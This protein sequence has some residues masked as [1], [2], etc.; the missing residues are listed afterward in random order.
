MTTNELTIHTDP[1]V[2]YDSFKNEP[3]LGLDLETTGINFITDDIAVIGI[4][5][6]TKNEVGIIHTINQGLPPVIKDLLENNSLKITQNGTAFDLPFLM[7]MDIYVHQHYDILIAEQVINTTNRKDVRNNLNAIMERRLG[8][9]FKQS[10]NHSSWS[11]DQLSPEQI[12]YITSDIVHLPRIYRIQQQLA[13][14][15]SLLESLESEQKLTT[16]TAQI[17]YNGLAFSTEKLHQLREESED[18]ELI[19]TYDLQR[20]FGWNF[21]PRSSQQ[22]IDV[23]NSEFNLNILDTRAGTLKPL[24]EH[25]DHIRKIVEVREASK[26]AGIYNSSFED[27]YITHDRLYA[28]YWQLGTDTTRFTSS[29]PN[30]Q[31]IPKDFR[32]VIGNESGHKVI[33]ADFS[34]IEIRV[35]AD[36]SKDPA[37]I[38][39]LESEDIHAQMASAIF[40]TP[41]PTSEQRFYGKFGTFTWLFAGGPNGI[42]EMAKAAGS[43]IEEEAAQKMINNLR[44]R[45]N[46][47]SQWHASERRRVN[48]K[49]PVIVYLPWGHRRVVVPPQQT[50][51]RLI[52]TK[53]QGTAAVGFKEALIEANRQGLT[54]YIGGLVHDEI[55]A[56]SVPEN[57]AEDY[58]ATLREAMITGM[59][60]VCVDVPVEVESK[61]ADSWTKE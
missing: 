28:K 3:F 19:Y 25:N 16:I 30:L 41:T 21:N 31:Q 24:A 36:I 49:Y 53:V 59:E 22:V 61:I 4:A 2:I 47:V 17:I 42:M 38:S 14:K 15:R 33:T 26:R 8:T 40:S 48:R 37:L 45:F 44:A 1:Q 51:Q 54:K 9:P 29:Q 55:V 39:A 60:K 27:K 12:R 43:T 7:N 13:N 11:T 50:V 52:N 46:R 6:A 18:K 35:A 10:I 20:E 58:E 56:T 23:L 57:E 32:S 34:Q 5:A